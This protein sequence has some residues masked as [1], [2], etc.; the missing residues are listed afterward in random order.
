MTL[1]LN[2]YLVKITKYVFTLEVLIVSKD[3]SN[4]KILIMNRTT[5]NDM[6]RIL[7][8]KRIT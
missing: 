5:I 3:I 4:N 2:Q 7:L 1:R 8:H 6:D